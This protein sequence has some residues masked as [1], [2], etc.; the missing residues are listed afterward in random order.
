MDQVLSA[1]A[2][3]CMLPDHPSIT[4][5]AHLR[6][7]PNEEHERNQTDNRKMKTPARVPHEGALGRNTG[8]ATCI[9]HEH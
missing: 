1:D 4:L 9:A 7:N 2:I 3:A 8:L 5:Y 6:L